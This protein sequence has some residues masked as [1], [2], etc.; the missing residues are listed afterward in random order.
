MQVHPLH[1]LA[2]PL[3]FALSGLFAAAVAYDVIIFRRRHRNRNNVI[4]RCSSCHHIYAE[5]HR[6]PLA[7]CP[8]CGKQNEPVRE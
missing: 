5:V 8:K 3:V 7:R 2:L 6:T 4:Y 1:L